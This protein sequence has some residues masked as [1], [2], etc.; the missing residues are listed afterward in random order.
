MCL[1][2]SE[3]MRIF[4]MCYE[5]PP[6]GGGAGHVVN[7]LC[8]QLARYGDDVT[9]MTMQYRELSHSEMLNG[10]N[11][12][13]IPCVRLKKYHCTIPEVATYLASGFFF[14]M[15]FVRK[16]QPNIIHAHFIL[17]D[18]LLARLI[19]FHC[20]IPYLITAH[21]TDVPNYNPHRAK[22]T[23]RLV[24]SIWRKTT[25]NAKNVIC[26][27]QS[28]KHLVEINA[29][30]AKTHI[31]PNGY[32]T[33][34]F[35]GLKKERRIIAVSRLL[36][37]KGIQY[38][39]KAV[40]DEDIKWEIVIAGNGTYL[41]ELRRMANASKSKIRFTGWLNNKSDEFY[42]LYESSSIFILPSESE[43]FPISL[44]EAML[45]RNAIIT[46]KGTGCEEVVGSTAWLVPPKDPCA[47]RK[48]L[49]EI[50]NNKELRIRMGELA[51]D[52]A[53]RLFGWPIVTQQYQ[54]LYRKCVKEQ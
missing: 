24:S 10:F 53:R 35:S 45:S 23:H 21:G 36:E 43:N 26:P 30:R 6:I 12:H 47:I 44:L 37:R 16:Y 46:T 40:A 41:N 42:R 34:R 50:I 14:A 29:P 54:K 28:I 18:G 51:R 31:I 15:Q 33:N 7:G 32:D 8:R 39:I 20:R 19:S 11:I 38:L 17:P 2:E 52:R 22:I 13:R 3:P 5:F 27:S 25:H 4:M 1:I 9:V 49:N 48:A